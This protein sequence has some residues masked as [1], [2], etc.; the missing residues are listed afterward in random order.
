M[1]LKMNN[2]YNSQSFRQRNHERELPS[3]FIIR[4]IVYTRMLLSVDAGG[5]L[6]VFYIMRKALV[7]WGANLTL[8]QNQGLRLVATTYIMYP[9]QLP[10]AIFINYQG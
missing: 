7:S 10:W 8:K 5:P 1:Q 6:E 2:Y 9:W 3:E 4:H